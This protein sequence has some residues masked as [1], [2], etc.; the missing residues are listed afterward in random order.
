MEERTGVIKC[1]SSKFFLQKVSLEA[2]F[3]RVCVV[4]LFRNVR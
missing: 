4:L 3:E 1:K 2:G